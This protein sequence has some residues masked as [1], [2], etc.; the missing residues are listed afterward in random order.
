VTP[1]PLPPVPT[2]V[3]SRVLPLLVYDPLWRSNII[4]D[5][6]GVEADA[7]QVQWTAWGG[8]W[9]LRFNLTQQQ[10]QVEDW[11]ENGL[12]RHVELYN[13]ALDM[14]WEGFV[15][16]VNVNIGSLT[17]Q[18]GG[19]LDTVVNRC[20]VVYSTVDTSTEP[21]TMGIRAATDWAE[22]ADSQARYGQIW[23][24][25]SVGGASEETATQ[26]RDTILD[27]YKEPTTEE[28]DNLGSSAEPSVTVEC[29]GYV[30]WLKVYTVDITGTG[31]QNADDKVTTV[32]GADP[33][34]LFSTDYVYIDE[35]TTQVAV[36]DRDDRTAW[37]VLKSLTAL[38]DD[39]Y[40]RWLFGLYKGRKAK[41]TALPTDTK[42]QRSLRDPSQ[43]LERYG[44]GLLV[45]PWD[46]TPGEWVFY[47]DLLIG[48]GPVTDKRT[49]PRY[50]L[51]E[52]NT[53]TAPWG[54]T[55]DGAKVGRID[56]LLAQLGL[57]G[58]AG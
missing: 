17:I 1:T 56:Q 36:Y 22:N 9:T 54:L 13:P 7:L 34:A 26:I 50:M 16:S 58:Q 8:Y 57:G 14:I 39:A 25:V 6:L 32:L 47:T 12:G 11:L 48:K 2:Y 23:R 18:R 33:N 10:T 53:Y 29:Q 31:T 44:T 46:A 4:S 41:Y 5:E 51:V 30:N 37:Q 3:Q 28:H 49:D 35:N 19:M 55:I 21:P 52:Q 20:R 24:V 27:E 40:N 43:S 42:Y 15:N 45:D 38:G